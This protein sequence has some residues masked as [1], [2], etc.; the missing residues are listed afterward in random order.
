MARSYFNYESMLRWRAEWL[1]KQLT[2][3]LLVRSTDRDF[4]ASR[5]ALLK[6]YV[7]F[8]F[9]PEVASINWSVFLNDV[10]QHSG[11]HRHQG[12]LVL[13]VIEGSGS[14]DIDGTLYKWKR[15]DLITLPIRPG[16]VEHQHFNDHAGKDCRWVA[17]YYKP[18]EDWVCHTMTHIQDH[19]DAPAPT[20]IGERVASSQPGLDL[21]LPEFQYREESAR[22]QTLYDAL[23]QIRDAQ[24][25]LR[26][27][28]SCIRRG[29]EL[30][31]EVN[32]HGIMRWYLHPLFQYTA[33]RN[34]N[35]YLQ[36][37]PPGSRSGLQKHPGDKVFFFLRGKGHTMVDG[38]RHDWGA[39]DL[40]ILPIRPEGVA[41]QHFNDDP[42]APAF[43][44]ACEPN[45]A[46]IFD[47]DRGSSFE[48]LEDAPEFKDESSGNDIAAKPPVF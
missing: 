34:F 32:A 1:E 26:G 21:K 36:C 15:G 2:G 3:R 28:A 44:F 4:E 17:F 38:V 16:G 18:F 40:L 7:T 20:G 37:L 42:S 14:T 11:R 25:Q 41:Y 6:R 22:R 12:G 48:E 19:T 13:F 30:P 35:A 43:L 8:E 27:P 9:T 45:L 23:M 5:Q 31:W 29:D 24:R 39:E 33:L 47:L 10:K 46:F